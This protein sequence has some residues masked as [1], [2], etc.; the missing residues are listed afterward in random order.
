[1]DLA[2]KL[3]GSKAGELECDVSGLGNP[4][5]EHSPVE[6]RSKN[7]EVS[8]QQKAKVVSPKP[9]P[10]IPPSSKTISETREGR[11]ERREENEKRPR[12]GQQEERYGE[13][14]YAGSDG[15]M[16]ILTKDKER[17]LVEERTSQ[18]AISTRH[19]PMSDT[20]GKNRLETLSPETNQG[21][22]K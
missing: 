9:L 3:H 11:A 16:D 14:N 13:S 18:G 19:G 12:R 5:A 2:L 1:M 21:W 22:G 8:E 10:P 7:F 6:K 17:R 15:D 4:H 20:G